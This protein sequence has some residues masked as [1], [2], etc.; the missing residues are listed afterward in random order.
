MGPLV[1]IAL[2]TSVICLA[3]R[4]R[5]GFQA[6]AGV[7]TALLLIVSFWVNPTMNDSRSGRAFIA[8]V[9]AAADP[10]APLGFVAFKEQYLLNVT[11]PVVHFGH[12]RWREGDQEAM[13][14]GR[15]MSG[16]PDRQL[17]VNQASLALCFSGA[18]I[19]PLGTATR[20]QWYLVRG[21]VEP[22][23]VRRGQADLAHF[24]N[25]PTVKSARISERRTSR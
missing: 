9:E 2:A 17:V 21:A 15:W 1:A 18:E 22:G 24:Y 10:S 7:L 16:A 5:R 12:A 8:R 20:I 23:C 25:P 11:R 14:A 3:L 6:F 19:E 4:P 13:D